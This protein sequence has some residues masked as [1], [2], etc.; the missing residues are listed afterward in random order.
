[1]EASNVV[2]HA[3]RLGLPAVV[4]RVS[5]KKGPG[6]EERARA[7]RYAALEAERKKRRFAWVATAH[8]AND[9]AETLLMRLS[10][11]SALLGAASILERRE[12]VIRPLLFATRHEVRAWLKVQGVTWHE[13]PMN[14]DP[15][16]LRTR[17]R[18]SVMPALEAA[19]D[20][21][22]GLRLARFARLASDDDALLQAQADEAYTRLRRARDRFD[23]RGLSALPPPLERRVLVRWLKELG[24]AVDGELIERMRHAVAAGGVTALPQRRL[25]KC[26]RGNAAIVIE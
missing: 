2:E 7:K 26:R 22:V 17:V 5:L 18:A 11:G 10:R 6:V 9:Q 24:L 23:S 4:R 15:S 12:R 3:R 1:V 25:L 19:T 20:S 21:R 8:T 13:D 16:L 14:D